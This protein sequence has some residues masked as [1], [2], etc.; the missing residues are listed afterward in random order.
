MHLSPYRISIFAAVI[1]SACATVPI[2]GRKQLDLVPQ[3]EL[4]SLS[5]DQYSQ[6]ITQSSLEQDPETSRQVT[7][8]GKEIAAAAEQFMKENG[9]ENDLKYYQWQFNA[10]KDDK[11]VNAFCMPGG[12]IAVY[13]GIL[14]ITRN[15]SGLA[16]VMGHE[17]AHAI[18]NH[19]GER[20]SQLLL[21]ELG[22]ATLAIAV[23]DQPAKTQQ[24]LM[25][26][27]G[28]GTAVGIILPYSRKQESEAD[29]IGLILMAKAGYDPRAAVGFWGRMAEG[30][31]EPGLA[32]FLGTHPADKRRIADIQSELPEA[33]KYYQS[34]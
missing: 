18:A 7:A 20:M 1:L 34:P 15:S 33:L 30:K 5:N 13:T 21:R 10:I 28:I 16:V 4:V 6:L 31:G 22:G 8:I 14:P 19:S 17:V 24:L 25:A 26:S 2:T 32:G 12:K 11:T 23:R 9:L 3:Q 29:R 27:F